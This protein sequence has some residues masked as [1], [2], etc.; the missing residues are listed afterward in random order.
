MT[1]FDVNL[2]EAA[3]EMEE[4]DVYSQAPTN[5]L[6]IWHYRLNHLPFSRLQTMAQNGE[7][8]TSLKECTVPQCAACNYAK[9]TKKPWRTKG[10]RFARELPTIRKAGDCVSVDQLELSTPGL[11]AQLRGFLTKERF[12]SATVFVDHHSGLSYVHLQR[13]TNAEETLTAK[14]AFEAWANTFGV[15]ILHYHADNGR[16]AERTFMSHCDSKGQTISFAG[17]NA[18]HQNG[19]A[20]KRIRD[21]QDTARTMLVH[22]KKRWP[23]AVSAHLWPYACLANSQRYFHLHRQR[24]RTISAGTLLRCPNKAQNQS[25]STIRMPRICPTRQTSSRTERA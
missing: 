11:I 10:R 8:P 20:E 4:K 19:I 18:H 1:S 14:V 21:L 3:Q 5:Q 16:F 24:R 12:N 7:L 23:K 17:V 6:L 25:L 13:S 15:K 22:A 2:A 9:A